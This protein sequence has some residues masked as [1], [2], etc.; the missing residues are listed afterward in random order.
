MSVRVILP[1][2]LRNMINAGAEVRLTVEAPVTTRAILNALE[3]HFPV[4]RGTIRDRATLERR[5]LVRFFACDE[6]WS[7]TDPETVLPEAIADGREPFMVVGAI[8]GG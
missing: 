7:H 8:A 4:L 2:H 1:H 5:P 6:D 3:A